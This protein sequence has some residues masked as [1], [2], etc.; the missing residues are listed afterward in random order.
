MK[1]SRASSAAAQAA[2]AGWLARQCR[3]PEAQIEVAE[4]QPTAM[5]AMLIAA[6]PKPLRRARRSSS[7]RGHADLGELAFDGFG[8]LLASRAAVSR[9]APR[10]RR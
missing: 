1:D 3:W 5:S 6:S 10:R 7:S 8:V 4:V 2:R 9:K